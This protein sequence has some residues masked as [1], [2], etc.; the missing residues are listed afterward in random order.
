[1]NQCQEDSLTSHK[2]VTTEEELQ[3]KW[4]E[5]PSEFVQSVLAYRREKVRRGEGFRTVAEINAEIERGRG[6]TD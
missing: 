1:M 5:H 4:T 6:H 2:Q 3:E